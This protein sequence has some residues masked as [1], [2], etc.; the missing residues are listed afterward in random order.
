[1]N[2]FGVFKVENDGKN[3]LIEGYHQIDI[4]IGQPGPLIFMSLPLKMMKFTEEL[5][6]FLNK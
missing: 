4:K 1:M 5:I 3:I 6:K 2:Y